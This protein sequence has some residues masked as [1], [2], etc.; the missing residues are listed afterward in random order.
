MYRLHWRTAK[1]LEPLTAPGCDNGTG[2]ASIVILPSDSKL[3]M[4]VFHSY[5]SSQVLILNAS[6]LLYNLIVIILINLIFLLQINYM[7]PKFLK[8]KK[9]FSK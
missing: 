3:Y 5:S 1:P 7:H 9:I 6:T 2:R 8:R 4:N